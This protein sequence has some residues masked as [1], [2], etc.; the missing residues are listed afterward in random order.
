M[1]LYDYANRFWEWAEM[2]ELS[3]NGV[4]LLFAVVQCAN[5]CGWPQELSIPLSKLTTLT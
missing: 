1:S 4:C 5:R 3:A 2:N